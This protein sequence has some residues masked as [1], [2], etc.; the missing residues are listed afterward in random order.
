MRFTEPLF[1]ACVVAHWPVYAHV[2]LFVIECCVFVCVCLSRR[3]WKRMK[4]AVRSCAGVG[5]VV[6]RQMPEGFIRLE[7]G[8]RE[9][10]FSGKS[11]RPKHKHRHASNPG[12]ALHSLFS[13]LTYFISTSLCLISNSLVQSAPAPTHLY[14]MSLFVS[15]FLPEFA[16]FYCPFWWFCCCRVCQWSGAVINQH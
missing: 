11:I 5:R 2:C 12:L 14:S 6:G 15:C 16:F 1:A 3:E 8:G 9:Q 10:Q 4:A 7:G 13:F